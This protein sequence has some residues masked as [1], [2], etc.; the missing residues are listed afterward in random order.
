MYKFSDPQI[1]IATIADIPT[2]KNL[3]NSAYRGEESKK[4]WTS[5]A[6]LIAGDTRTDENDLQKVMTMTGSVFLKYTDGAGQVA[7]CVNLQQHGDRMYLGMFS[8][9]PQKQGA[10]I[11]KKI[12]L[13]SEEY[14]ASLNCTKMYMSVISLRTELINWY[15]RYG[16]NDTG[17]RKP[18]IEDGLTG[19][20]LQPL[21][22]MIMEKVL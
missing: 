9:S 2:I 20:H 11:G 14:A 6:H 7:G 5:E 18:F 15:K 16:Y 21:E 22:F 1:T 10:G 8:V 17:R 12:L 13:I 3:L 4:T 19:K